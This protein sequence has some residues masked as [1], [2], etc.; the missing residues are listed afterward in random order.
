MAEF[1]WQ[2]GRDKFRSILEEGF[3][4]LREGAVEA[5]HITEATIDRLKM[6][7][8]IKRLL[9]HLNHLRILL[10][11]EIVKLFNQVPELKNNKIITR[12]VSEILLGETELKKKQKS[13]SHLTVVQKRKR[14]AAARKKHAK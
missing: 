12:L 7:M 9:S 5:Q 2:K 11:G 8:E 14:R 4:Y 3:Q 1:D 6:E 10:G 13:I